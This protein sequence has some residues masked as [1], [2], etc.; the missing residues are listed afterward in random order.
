MHSNIF[1][2]RTHSYPRSI[3]F[4][5]KLVLP[6]LSNTKMAVLLALLYQA[7][8]NLCKSYENMH[9]QSLRT[10]YANSCMLAL[11]HSFI[12]VLDPSPFPHTLILLTSFMNALFYISSYWSEA[13]NKLYFIKFD[14]FYQ[15]SRLSTSI[16]CFCLVC[17]WRIYIRVLL[18]E[19]C[20]YLWTQVLW[21][22]LVL[23]PKKVSQFFSKFT[24]NFHL[25]EAC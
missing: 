7:C 21:S 19:L 13:C 18:L 25:Q 5:S 2:C 16:K 17:I 22:Y 14:Y 20:F 11:Y 10:W 23:H 24:V 1:H 9:F 3:K 4:A 15:L 12:K 6:L 8:A